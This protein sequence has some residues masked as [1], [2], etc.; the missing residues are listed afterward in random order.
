M[1]FVFCLSLKLESDTIVGDILRSTGT[2]QTTDYRPVVLNSHL[3]KKME[4]LV[5]THLVLW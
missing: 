1:L 4:R 2:L 5:L 3:M